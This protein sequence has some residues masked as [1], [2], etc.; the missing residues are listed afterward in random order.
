ML[1]SFF[2][3]QL[4][5]SEHNA[6]LEKHRTF[7]AAATLDCAQAF[8]EVL[9]N[10]PASKRFLTNEL[11]ENQLKGDL[12]R[13][14]ATTLSAKQDEEAVLKI[15]N[16]QRHV[17]EVH[18]RI[19]VPMSLVNSAMSVI[20][21]VL[22]NDIQDNQ[23]I[24]CHEK[25]ELVILLNTLLDSSLSLINESYLEGRVNNERTAQ[26][27]RN[28]STAHEI[29][30]E[31]ERIRG[32]LFGWM[33]QFMADLLSGTQQRLINIHHQ[34]FALWI[35]HKLGFVCMDDRVVN[36]IKHNL[37]EL[38]TSLDALYHHPDQQ[39]E[40]RVQ[41]ISA[42]T[43]E[44]GWLLGQIADHNIEN[45]TREDALTSL[46]ERRFMPPILQSETQLAIKTNTPYSIMMIDIDNFK[47]VNDIHGHQA[48]DAVLSSIGRTL[49]RSLR[50]TDYAFR[51]G[52]EEFM[53]LMP[54]T[55]LKNAERAAEKLLDKIRQTD[56]KIDNGRLLKVT[57]SI[58]LAAFDGHPDYEQIIKHADE[59]LYEAKHNGKDR[60]EA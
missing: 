35:R 29:A 5:T 45:A 17:G 36:K 56:I 26:E 7:I 30:I 1:Q 48:G 21:Q 18:T 25:T 13:W 14:L 3:G 53:I 52:G 38:Q 37:D 6:L 16:I 59:K 33:T 32:A 58:G 47:K 10:D 60:Y 55:A 51:Y 42:L 22:F 54:E 31:V 49:K 23:A 27:Y 41:K 43:N 8:Y 39:R 11:V 15:V 9:L 24:G 28:R 46:I 44:C 50:V 34:E 2:I 20:K 19:D 57:A 4:Y 12:Q 40:E